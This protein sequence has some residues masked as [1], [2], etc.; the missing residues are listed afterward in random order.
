MNDEMTILNQQT[1]LTLQRRRVGTALVETGEQVEHLATWRFADSRNVSRVALSIRSVYF[2]GALRR[3]T[4]S[5]LS[6]EP[7]CLFME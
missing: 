6:F 3:L 2:N 5:G 1:N 4:P 7:G